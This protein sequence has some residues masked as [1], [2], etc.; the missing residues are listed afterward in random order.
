MN[1]NR[2]KNTMCNIIKTAI[3]FQYAHAINKK[4]SFSAKDISFYTQRETAFFDA[5]HEYQTAVAEFTASLLLDKVS[6][7]RNEDE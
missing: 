4:N 2:I 6:V 7:T 1:T 5:V 3:E